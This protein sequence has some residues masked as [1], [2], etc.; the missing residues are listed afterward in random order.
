MLNKVHMFVNRYGMRGKYFD[1]AKR[2][3]NSDDYEQAI[4]E[5]L[6]KNPITFRQVTE[7]LCEKAVMDAKAQL[8]PLLH[9][10]DLEKL[11][12]R[13]EFVEAFQH[14][15][16]GVVAER[17]ALWLPWVKVVYRFDAL[18]RRSTD[19]W[20]NT[21]HLLILVPQLLPSMNEFGTILDREMLK[22]LQHLS[23]SRFQDAKSI[24]EIQQVTP[25]ELRHGVCYGAMFYSFY[26]APTQ[27]WPP[28]LNPPN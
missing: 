22:R 23:W 9:Q 12:Q 17:I 14:S 28:I 19:D 5:G 15:L 27:V 7:E 1:E 2:N 26:T 8:H 18:R 11:G 6:L 4:I 16:E 3:K 21:L 10:V 20:D 24:V 13:R 25:N